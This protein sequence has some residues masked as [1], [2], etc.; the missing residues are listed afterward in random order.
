MS[1]LGTLVSKEPWC[2]FY[3]TR[4]QVY[5]GLTHYVVFCWYSDLISH[6]R[7]H[8]QRHTAHSGPVDL[9][10][11][12]NIYLHHLLYAHSSC[13]CYIGHSLISKNC[14]P[15]CLSFST[16]IHLTRLCTYMSYIHIY[17]Y[18]YKYIYIVAYSRT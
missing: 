8:T 18:I 3:A 16:I 15:W 12:I 10:T 5:W 2:V 4:H 9:N 7:K 13:L 14:F 11:H 1:S 6:I 17:I